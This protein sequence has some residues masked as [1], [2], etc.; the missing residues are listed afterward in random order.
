MGYLLLTVLKILLFSCSK[1][2]KPNW[3]EI[4]DAETLWDKNRTTRSTHVRIT[5]SFFADL[6]LGRGHKKAFLKAAQARDLWPM[7]KGGLQLIGIVT[8]EMCKTS[9]VD[10]H[11]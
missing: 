4:N 6:E 5:G 8:V 11:D 3:C 7:P 10:I 2:K 1:D 9:D